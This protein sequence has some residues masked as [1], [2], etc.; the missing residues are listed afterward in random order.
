[1]TQPSPSSP[2][3]ASKR[4]QVTLLLVPCMLLAVLCLALTAAFTL[5]PVRYTPA[6]VG[7]AVPLVPWVPAG[8]VVINLFL[9]GSLSWHALAFWAAW[10][11][12]CVFIYLVYGKSLKGL[13]LTP[14]NSSNSNYPTHPRRAPAPA[15]GTRRVRRAVVLSC[16]SVSSPPGLSPPP[17]FLPVALPHLLPPPLRRSPSSSIVPVA[18]HDLPPPSP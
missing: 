2:H 7:F 1:M 15:G 13:A 8:G 4:K 6:G 12:V 11:A 14:S 3:T 18:H 9:I 17:V 10:M 5:M 16:A